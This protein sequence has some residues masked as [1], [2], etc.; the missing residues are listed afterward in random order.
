MNYFGTSR[1]TKAYLGEQISGENAT[2]YGLMMLRGYILQNGL[3]KP[4]NSANNRFVPGE[5][6]EPA[7]QNG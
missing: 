3:T 4:T 1:H 2:D 5:P 7:S 6:V